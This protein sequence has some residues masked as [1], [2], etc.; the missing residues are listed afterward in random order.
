[1]NIPGKRNKK[2]N[3]ILPLTKK[4]I[5]PVTK[6]KKKALMSSLASSS[7]SPLL[8]C[9]GYSYSLGELARSPGFKHCVLV[10]FKL[11]IIGQ[12][13][14]LECQTYLSNCI[15]TVS[16]RTPNRHLRSH[17]LNRLWPSSPSW[18]PLPHP[19]S[20]WAKYFVVSTDPSTDVSLL[21]CQYMPGRD[22]GHITECIIGS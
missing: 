2:Q 1:M 19:S 10:S 6:K 18:P 22:F 7:Q 4:E 3:K 5:L 20:I 14:S 11:D 13:P 21:H 15:L 9:S 8:L 12:G 17:I 16:S